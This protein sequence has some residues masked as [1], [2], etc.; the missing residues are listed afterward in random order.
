M[1][2]P[3][4]NR[5]NKHRGTLESI[6]QTLHTRYTAGIR[7]RL[8]KMNKHNHS[9]GNDHADALANQVAGGHHPNTTNITCSDV[10]LGT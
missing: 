9:L 4:A 8:G 6:T 3:T 10:S 1:R 7:T 2:S 5:H